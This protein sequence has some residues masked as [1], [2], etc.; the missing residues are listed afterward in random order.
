MNGQAGEFREVMR[1]L[2]RRDVDGVFDAGARG[3]NADERYGFQDKLLVEEK[4]TGNAKTTSRV[5]GWW[6]EY[7]WTT[8]SG[9]SGFSRAHNVAANSNGGNGRESRRRS[10]DIRATGDRK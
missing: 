3:L 5:C 2:A 6:P 7:C 1:E 9:S 10:E 4:R 8:E